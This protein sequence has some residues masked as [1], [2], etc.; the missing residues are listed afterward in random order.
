MN[1]QVMVIELQ[2]QE[3]LE[4]KMAHIVE[5]VDLAGSMG[6]NING[7]MDENDLISKMKVEEIELLSELIYKKDHNFPAESIFKSEIELERFH[8]IVCRIL[9][10]LGKY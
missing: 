7:F 4:Q 3:V 6:Y 1:T 5:L 9:D 10:A 8:S 2:P